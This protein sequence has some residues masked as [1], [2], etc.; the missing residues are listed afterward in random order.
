MLQANGAPAE[1]RP[2]NEVLAI[3]ECGLDGLAKVPMEIQQK[4]FRWHYEWSERLERPMV[5]HCVR[6]LDELM[7]LRREWKPSQVWIFHGFRGKPQQLKSLVSAGFYVSFGFRFNE[8]S[9]RLCPAERLLLESDNDPR[10]IRGLY[11]EAAKIR[12]TSLEELAAQM[13]IHFEALFGVR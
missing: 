6:A 5:I 7:R 2:A 8:E 1:W 4:L 11:E 10:P 3:G 13:E 12:M 9:M